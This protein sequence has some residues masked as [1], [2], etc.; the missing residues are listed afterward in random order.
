MKII[1]LKLV[2][3]L[4][5]TSHTF[6]NESEADFAEIV[7]ILQDLMEFLKF[8]TISWDE[9]LDQELFLFILKQP[10]DGTATPYGTL[11]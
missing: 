6:R 3:W 2:A 10:Y 7:K 1:L 5:Y 9:H 11:P 4:L 8:S